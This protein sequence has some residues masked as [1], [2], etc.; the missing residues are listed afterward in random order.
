MYTLVEGRDGRSRHV[1]LRHIV[2]RDDGWNIIHPGVGRVERLGDN[3]GR[4][5]TEDWALAM[6]VAAYPHIRWEAR[7]VR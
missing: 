4:H 2:Q 7:R 3:Y 5:E 6:L 1:R